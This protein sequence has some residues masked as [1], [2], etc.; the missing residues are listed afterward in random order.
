MPKESQINTE[1]IQYSHILIFF[2]FFPG[3]AVV[4]KSFAFSLVTTVTSFEVGEKNQNFFCR[5][6]KKGSPV[7]AGYV[8]WKMGVSPLINLSTTT[9]ILDLKSGSK[10]GHRSS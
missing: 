5:E 2:Y 1:I 4:S 10:D 6:R 9:Y 3:T 7:R 8:K